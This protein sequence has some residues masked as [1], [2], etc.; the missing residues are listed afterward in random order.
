MVNTDVVIIIELVPSPFKLSPGV[1]K[2]AKCDPI[3][4][5]NRSSHLKMTGRLMQVNGGPSM[6]K[7][8]TH[9]SYLQP[10]LC[11]AAQCRICGGRP[12]GRKCSASDDIPSSD[13]PLR[14][15]GYAQIGLDCD[16]VT[17]TTDAS[18]M[19]RKYCDVQANGANEKEPSL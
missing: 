5:G 18:R 15:C 1:L 10:D 19:V 16:P 2:C 11:S 12:T 7:E 14:R 13:H 17:M 6:R 3:V 9:I 8:K 4:I